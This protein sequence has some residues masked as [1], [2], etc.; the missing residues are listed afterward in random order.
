MST[1]EPLLSPVPAEQQTAGAL[2]VVGYVTA[3]VLP[4]IGF[5]LGIVVATRPVRATSKHGA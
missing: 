2:V 5:I 3:A 4:L 1:N